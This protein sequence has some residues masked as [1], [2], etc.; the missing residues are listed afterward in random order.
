LSVQCAE[1]QSALVKQ[2]FVEEQGGQR[3]PPQS[4]SVS[5]P[6]CAPSLQVATWQTLPA[7]T[8]VTQSLPTAQCFAAA[9]LAHDAPPQSTSVSPPF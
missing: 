9:H 4:V 3:P 1:L 5:K 2:R 8:E 6:F 7:Q